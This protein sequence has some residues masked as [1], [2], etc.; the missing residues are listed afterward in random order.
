[1]RFDN[2]LVFRTT[3]PTQHAGRVHALLSYA[4]FLLCKHIL[5]CYELVSD[6]VEIFRSIQ[7]RREP[8]FWT[9]P[10]SILQPQYQSLQAD[11]KADETNVGG[12]D[13]DSDMD[14]DGDYDPAIVEQDQL[15]ELEE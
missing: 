11:T 14:S 8:P 4:R 1:M 2:Q 9:H 3:T 10:Q 6:R 13:G 15:V 7:R 5:Y 12:T